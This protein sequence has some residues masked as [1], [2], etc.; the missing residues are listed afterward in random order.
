MDTLFSGIFRPPF[1]VFSA[2]QKEHTYV[3]SCKYTP[4]TQN[5]KNSRAAQREIN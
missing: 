2:R 1:F 4:R 5:I 3:Q